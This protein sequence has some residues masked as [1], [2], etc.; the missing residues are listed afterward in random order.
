MKRS[1]FVVPAVVTAT[2]VGCL[3]IGPLGTAATAG[4]AAATV[5]AKAPVRAQL[6]HSPVA[7]PAGR[8]AAG[9]PRVAEVR[10]H[11]AA[12]A[13]PAIAH[14]APQLN[15]LAGVPG[16]PL[17]NSGV[18][19]EGDGSVE[20]T[21]TGPAALAAAKA[22]GARTLASFAGSTTVALAPGKLR[23]LAGQPGVSKVAPAVRAQPQS[24]SE[25]VA[26]S[27]AQSW[28]QTGDVGNGGAGVKVGIVDL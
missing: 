18:R 2:V 25:G 24:T 8:W 13:R 11:Q 4:P 16:S 26:A 1:R 6:K 10:R 21:V 27:G 17:V 14:L 7:I 23:S 3:G 22:V 20:V 9:S 28:A 12:P 15:R 5:T 19:L